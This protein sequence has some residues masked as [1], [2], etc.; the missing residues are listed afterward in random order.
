[1]CFSS[2]IYWL[3]LLSG[4]EYDRKFKKKRKE[5]WKYLITEAT[6]LGGNPNISKAVSTMWGFSI[7]FSLNR[8]KHMEKTGVDSAALRAK[9]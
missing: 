5:G 9:T 4:R 2:E 7:P 8:E 1:M 3:G 6:S